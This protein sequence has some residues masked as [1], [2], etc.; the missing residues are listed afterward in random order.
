MPIEKPPWG[1]TPYLKFSIQLYTFFIPY[2][3]ALFSNNSKEWILWAPEPTLSPLI[4]KTKLR[5][6]SGSS[7]YGIEVNIEQSLGNVWIKYISV[8]YFSLIIFAN[9]FSY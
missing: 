6:Y 9:C 2:S 4:Y 1:G 7:V 3:Q 8:L 5:T